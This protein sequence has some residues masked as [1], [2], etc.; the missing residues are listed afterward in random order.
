MNRQA[1]RP[2][3]KSSAPASGRA[4]QS[5]SSTALALSDAPIGVFDSGVGGLS[6]AGEILRRLPA[7]S[8]LYFA[9][10]AH[11][12]YGGRPLAE[13]QGFA[14]AICDFLVESGAKIVVMA[15]NIS[16]AVAL[17][18]ARERH[19]DI[20]MLGVIEPGAAAALATGAKRI[21]VLATQGTVTSGA[22]TRTITAAEPAAEVVEVACP[23]FV[24]LVEAGETESVDARDAAR[25]YLSPLAKA[26][27]QAIILGCTHYPFLL[28]IL[29]RVA[30][31]LFGNGA[32]PAFVDPAQETT[33]EIGCL[34]SKGGLASLEGS[35]P[36]HRY[37]VSGDVD[38][39]EAQGSAFLGRRI[40]GACNIRL[41]EF[42]L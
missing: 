42:P 3:R 12:P 24:P 2:G 19:P 9:D 4:E 33:R 41:D 23:R 16:S 11:V 10:T 40:A 26:G 15:C 38:R 20:P 22:Y 39:F 21:G 14:L 28:P 8:V 27:C 37:F 25:E 29:R 36:A 17:P 30:G 35:Q 31:E 13:V 7:E 32:L 1:E 5:A 34:L 6:V 18:A